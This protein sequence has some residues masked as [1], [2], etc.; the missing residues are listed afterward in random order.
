[1]PN[2]QGTSL[3]SRDEGGPLYATRIASRGRAGS[4]NVVGTDGRAKITGCERT[5]AAYTR[6]EHALGQGAGAAWQQ[7]AGA[8]WEQG[9]EAA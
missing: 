4:D 2:L 8:A 7:G 1:M 6:L 9:A 3:V 5:G